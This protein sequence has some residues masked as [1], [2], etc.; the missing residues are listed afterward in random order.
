MEPVNTE[1]L[2]QASGYKIRVRTMGAGGAGASMESLGLMASSFS[3]KWE[4]TKVGAL[5]LGNN[6]K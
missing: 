4:V 5:G 6:T 1:N 3:C 2:F